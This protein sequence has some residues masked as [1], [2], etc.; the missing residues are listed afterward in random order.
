MRDLLMT[1]PAASIRRGLNPGDNLGDAP[2]RGQVRSSDAYFLYSNKAST[3]G[4]DLR[5]GHAAEQ[6]RRGWKSTWLRPI[7][8]EDWRRI[9]S[10][11]AGILAPDRSTSLI[12]CGSRPGDMARLGYL[13]LREG[14]WEDQQLLP[15]AGGCGESTSQLIF[16]RVR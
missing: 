13:M 8:R 2:A 1:R 10:R 11:R 16:C 4:P 3:P 9:S 14:K 15:A 12:T 6:L 7:G 5:K